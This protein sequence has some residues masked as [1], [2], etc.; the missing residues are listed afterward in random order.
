MAITETNTAMSARAR[1]KAVNWGMVSPVD[2]ITSGYACLMLVKTATIISL[3]GGA[4]WK[5]RLNM[6]NA[7]WPGSVNNGEA[8]PTKWC[9][10]DSAAVRLPVGILVCMMMPLPRSGAVLLLTAITMACVNG[11]IPTPIKRLPRHACNGLPGGPA[12]S[13]I[14]I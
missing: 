8:T 4:M 11:R 13:L 2:V 1:W 5:R 7:K 9:Y 12:L 14:L 6:P 10:V 3:P